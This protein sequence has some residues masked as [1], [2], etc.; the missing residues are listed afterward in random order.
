[1]AYAQAEPKPAS[2]VCY[3]IDAHGRRMRAVD[4]LTRNTQMIA[5]AEDMSAN[6][7]Q[8]SEYRSA[9]APDVDGDVDRYAPT[10]PVGWNILGA[11]AISGLLWWALIVAGG[12]LLRALFG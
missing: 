5:E 6:L 12:G 7:I 3:C 10:W 4:A 2:R 11:L 8:L 1:M 9:P